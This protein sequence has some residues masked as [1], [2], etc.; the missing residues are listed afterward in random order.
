[1][2]ENLPRSDALRESLCELAE[3]VGSAVKEDVGP[4][5]EELSQVRSL[6]QDAGQQLM[7]AFSKLDSGTRAQLLHVLQMQAETAA[8]HGRSAAEMESRVDE[9]G[10]TSRQVSDSIDEAV[11]ALQ[12]EDMATQL[13]DCVQRRIA[14]LD[15]VTRHMEGIVHQFED[16]SNEAAGAG[17]PPLSLLSQQLTSLKN[18]YAT[19]LISPVAAKRLDD[20]GSIDLF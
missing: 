16:A 13:I 20:G 19:V 4:I 11:R 9:I 7:G 17:L 18:E 1:M 6:L 15:I 14:R 8:L 2:S 5:R 10:R 12:F 3:T